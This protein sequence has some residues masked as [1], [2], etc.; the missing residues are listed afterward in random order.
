[1]SPRPAAWKPLGSCGHTSAALNLNGDMFACLLC[2]F[3][4]GGGGAVEGLSHPSQQTEQSSSVYLQP[5]RRIISAD[6]S[7]YLPSLLLLLLLFTSVF[8]KTSFSSFFCFVFFLLL[9][10]FFLCRRPLLC[11]CC[12]EWAQGQS[13]VYPLIWP[14]SPDKRNAHSRW[15]DFVLFFFVRSVKLP[16]FI[17][18]EL[19]IYNFFFFVCEGDVA[20]GSKHP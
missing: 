10:F 13:R 17:S 2:I 20:G 14:A 3:N 8:L 5:R 11:F 1:M 16:P 4:N 7:N 18:C 6:W 12:D 15:H 19:K 9:L